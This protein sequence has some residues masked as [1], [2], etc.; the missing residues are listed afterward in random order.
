MARVS[1]PRITP[2]LKTIPQ[3][4]V[5]VDVALG[6]LRPISAKCALLHHTSGQCHT[7]EVLGLRWGETAEDSRGAK[8]QHTNAER[9]HSVA[10]RSTR[11][12]ESIRS[13]HASRN[14]NIFRERCHHSGRSHQQGVRIRWAVRSLACSTDLRPTSSSVRRSKAEM[15]R[16]RATVSEQGC[17]MEQVSREH[18]NA[19]TAQKTTD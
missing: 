19:I 5:P 12:R 10:H 15:N 9:S 11:Q 17:R 16:Q 8:P 3:I 14:D 7:R 13:H 6:A 4:V 18:A 1:A 2:S